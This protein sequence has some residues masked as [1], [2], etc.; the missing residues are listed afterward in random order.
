MQFFWLFGPL[1]DA[2]SLGHHAKTH[3]CQ[4]KSK[5][6]PDTKEY[7]KISK[8]YI[9]MEQ[10]PFFLTMNETSLYFSICSIYKINK[11]RCIVDTTVKLK[12]FTRQVI[13][14]QISKNGIKRITYVYAGKVHTK[15]RCYLYHYMQTCILTKTRSM[16]SNS[17]N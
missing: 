3:Y 2:P 1:R 6:P 8:M 7:M 13:I 14:P 5:V 16:R 17:F 10:I 4:S 9:G 12:C 11:Y 15:E